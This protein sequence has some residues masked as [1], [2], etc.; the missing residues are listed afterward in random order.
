MSEIFQN[1]F[2]KEMEKKI[3]AANLIKIPIDQGS[4]WWQVDFNSAPLTHKSTISVKIKEGFTHKGNS[5]DYVEKE[6]S[7]KPRLW[8]LV[9]KQY[10]M[11]N[12][13]MKLSL[14][15]KLQSVK[16]R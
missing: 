14:F 6:N 10:L 15:L 3:E 7:S 8:S 1:M 12:R 5:L 2:A 13:A 16:C 4:N 11:S 9:E